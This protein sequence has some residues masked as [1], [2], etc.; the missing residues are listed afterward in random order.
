[1]SQQ[2][3]AGLILL[4]C[5]AF[6]LGCAT[7]QVPELDFLS[8]TLRP[9]T[10][11]GAIPNYGISK[12]LSTVS[13]PEFSLT[14]HSINSL[15]GIKIALLDDN[16]SLLKEEFFFPSQSDPQT[17]SFKFSG[18]YARTALRIKVFKQSGVPYEIALGTIDD[19]ASI[20]DLGLI[21]V[22]KEA[23]ATRVLEQSSSYRVLKNQDPKTFQKT[24]LEVFEKRIE[25]L[26]N[27]TEIASNM[28]SAGVDPSGNLK[29]FNENYDPIVFREPTV[30][31]EWELN[32]FQT[33]DLHQ[34]EEAQSPTNSEISIDSNKENNYLN[35]A[36]TITNLVKQVSVASSSPRLILYNS[37]D[38][39]EPIS[40]VINQSSVELEI[41]FQQ[42]LSLEHRIFLEKEGF[43]QIVRKGASYQILLKS[44]NLMWVDHSKLHIMIPF[45]WPHFSFDE[46]HSIILQHSLQPTNPTIIPYLFFKALIVPKQTG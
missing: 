13:I 4:I 7:T 33:L 11:Q 17:I 36:K 10:L 43:I 38:Q 20:H 45:D 41:Y 27:W 21:E 42:A 15:P 35:Q 2:N 24:R 25:P 29:I 30:A 40:R 32:L 26:K 18:R 6:L 46:T 8:N 31:T 34:V 23:L 19:N 5:M 37:Y 1:M 39:N 3:S 9:V 14:T 12:N 28:N 44:L 22:E 16:S